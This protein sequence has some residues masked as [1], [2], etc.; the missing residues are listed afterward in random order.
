MHTSLLNISEAAN[1]AIHAMAVMAQAGKKNIGPV[2]ATYIGR[3]LGSSESHIS[4]VLQRLAKA[5]LAL[6]TRGARGGFF[7]PAR[8]APVTALEILAAIDGPPREAACLLGV[9]HCTPGSCRLHGLLQ[10]VRR[11]VEQVLGNI[12]IQDFSIHLLPQPVG[13]GK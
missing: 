7:L 4:K 9:P 3:C 10:I 2:S 6:S 12:T 13:S 1:L 8:T 5:G 11:Q